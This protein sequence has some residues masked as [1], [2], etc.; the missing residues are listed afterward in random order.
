MMLAMSKAPKPWEHA[1][2][3]GS[4]QDK[5]AQRFVSSLD[6]DRRLY[7]HD[8]A[9]SVAHARMLQHVGLITADDLTAILDGADEA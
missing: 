1:K 3:G 2:R 7:K 6:I 5:L 4:E 9:G 8:I